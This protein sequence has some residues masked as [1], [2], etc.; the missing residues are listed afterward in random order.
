[1]ASVDSCQPNK[2]KSINNFRV[3]TI[4]FPILAFILTAEIIYVFMHVP[5]TLGNATTV[6][7]KLPKLPNII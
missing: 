2:N 3:Y 6:I 7:G 5:G 1:M 4:I